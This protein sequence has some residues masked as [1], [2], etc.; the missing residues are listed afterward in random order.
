M[1]YKCVV[2]L[3]DKQTGEVFDNLGFIELYHRPFV[4]EEIASTML[5]EALQ[6]RDRERFLGKA[7]LF[8]VK[9]VRH[10]EGCGISDIQ[11]QVDDTYLVISVYLD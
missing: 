7:A 11:H 6:P 10:Q 2:N 5:Y 1:S 9:K 4:G 3:V 8:Q